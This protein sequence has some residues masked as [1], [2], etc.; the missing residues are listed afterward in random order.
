MACAGCLNGDANWKKTHTHQKGVCG[1]FIPATKATNVDS[2]AEVM[3]D[4]EAPIRS[5]S[6]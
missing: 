3:S 4:A 1:A 2:S 6:Y 5:A